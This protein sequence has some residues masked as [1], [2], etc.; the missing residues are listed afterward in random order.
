MSGQSPKSAPLGPL[1][2]AGRADTD[3]QRKLRR[4][5]RRGRGVRVGRIIYLLITGTLLFFGIRYLLRY[6]DLINSLTNTGK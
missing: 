3:E 5:A 6:V 4:A 1:D 2:Y